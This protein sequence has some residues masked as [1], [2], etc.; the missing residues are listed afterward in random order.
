[1]NDCYFYSLIFVLIPIIFIF[2]SLYSQEYF[3]ILKGV[4]HENQRLNKLAKKST[5]FVQNGEYELDILN[6]A[7]EKFTNDNVDENEENR[8]RVDALELLFVRN[9]S[10]R[11]QETSQTYKELGDV[12]LE[13]EEYK[14][15]STGNDDN[16]N[17][18]VTNIFKFSERFHKD[19]Q[20]PID[21]LDKHIKNSE[22]IIHISNELKQLRK[23]NNSHI[24]MKYDIEAKI[25]EERRIKREK[26][27]QQK[28]EENKKDE[29]EPICLD[30][31]YLSFFKEFPS[32]QSRLK[33]LK[34][35]LSNVI[36]EEKENLGK[37]DQSLLA[38]LS[39]LEDHKIKI[40][41]LKYPSDVFHE[42]TKE[43]IKSHETVTERIKRLYRG[44]ES[45]F[46]DD[47][48][49]IKGGTDMLAPEDDVTSTDMGV[50]IMKGAQDNLE[51]MF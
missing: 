5:K 15:N 38:L 18:F 46:S 24:T 47:N 41:D 21:I 42:K 22:R 29:E 16:Y 13:S 1:M 14:S 20:R 11:T 3:L 6:N 37:I 26:E 34:T 31:M 36:E 8:I 45:H 44:I 35:Q 27:R 4:Q 25:R 2:L 23:L 12:Y 10:K 39:E 50:V 48:N 32:F 9:E 51:D 17:T 49:D 43:Y 30:D 7:T 33:T 40:N 19:M 28:H